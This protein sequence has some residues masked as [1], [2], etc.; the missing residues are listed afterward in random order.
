MAHHDDVG[1]H[2]VERDRRVDQRFA[3]AHRGGADRHVHDVGA[4]PFAGELE[5]GLGAGRDLEE[6]I[7]QRAPAQRHLLLVDLAVE[8]DEILG[9]VKQP[10]NLLARK[11]FDPQQMAL[12]EDEGGLWCDVH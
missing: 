12:V 10:Q 4:E 7:D 6:K 3:L 8:L 2:G 9:E 11:P 1:M 5:G